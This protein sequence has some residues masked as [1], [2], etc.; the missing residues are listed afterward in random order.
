MQVF[1]GTSSGAETLQGTTSG[2]AVYSQVAPLNS[3]TAVPALNTTICKIIA[4]DSGWP[5]GTGYDTT[6]VATNGQTYPG[7]PVRAQFLGPG[8][9]INLGQGFPRYNGVVN[10]PVPILAQP[11]G[12]GP[13]SISGP[14]SLGS[15]GSNYNLTSV[16]RIGILTA[17]PAWGVDAEG[18][19]LSGA[20][21]ANVGYLFN[22]S[23]PLNHLLVGNGSYYVDSATIPGSALNLFYQ[24]VALNGTAQTQRPT[25]NFSSYF[26]ATDSA[27]P[28]E[29]TI[30]PVTTGSETK[31]VTA[32]SAGTSGDCAQWDS[33][34]GLGAASAP[35]QTGVTHGG[36]ATG[37]LSSGS[38][39]STTITWNGGGFTSSTYSAVCWG[40]GLN[41]GGSQAAFVYETSQTATQ[42]VVTTS[43]VGTTNPGGFAT[44]ICIGTSN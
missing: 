16:G 15:G 25:L 22:G 28:A 12:H 40:S 11:Y 1:I 23:A 31:L 33:S 9:N 17:T 19:G 30:A 29:T 38:P 6:L 10:Y 34:G 4:N 18:A 26:T 21:N 39:C 3:G 7:Y 2:S 41:S 37:C 43:N 8:N 5:T 13:Q 32:A 44:I 20:I 42:I 36:S 35:C 14:L 27:S 24:T